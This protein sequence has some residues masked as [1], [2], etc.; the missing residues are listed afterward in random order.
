MTSPVVDHQR[1]VFACRRDQRIGSVAEVQVRPV[2]VDRGPDRAVGGLLTPD[3]LDDDSD[4]DG[5]CD[6]DDICPS[7][8][9][10]V[11]TDSDGAT[12]TGYS[13]T[14]GTGGPAVISLL[15]DTLLPRL[16][17]REAEM[18]ALQQALDR[19]RENAGSC[20]TR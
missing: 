5:S 12:G 19:L 8:D 4:G 10:N 20:P 18:R 14:I 9:D 11:D 1:R 15:R 6:S 13:Y 17:G 16:I 2:D 3:H 7:G